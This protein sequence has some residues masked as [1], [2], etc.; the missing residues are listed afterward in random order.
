MKGRLF[1]PAAQRQA[2][3]LAG[4][5]MLGKITK[6]MPLTV[7]PHINQEIVYLN[8]DDDKHSDLVLEGA[9]LIS[10][11]VRAQKW[12]PIFITAG[13][14]AI[15]LANEL[16]II[17]AFQT[18]IIYNKE[19][20]DDMNPEWVEYHASTGNQKQRLSLCKEK[21]KEL[22]GRD[23]I[24]LDSVCTR[25]NTLR[26]THRLLLAAGVDPSRILCAMVL[27]TQGEQL[28]QLQMA[29][30]DKLNLVSF[31]HLDMKD[32]ALTQRDWK[33][34]LQSLYAIEVDAEAE[35]RALSLQLDDE[36]ARA[37]ACL[38]LRVRATD[39]A[40]P[41]DVSKSVISR[42]INNDPDFCAQYL[43]KKL[44]YFTKQ[45]INHLSAWV[46]KT[47]L[48]PIHQSLV[49]FVHNQVIWHNTCIRLFL[50]Q[51]LSAR[52]DFENMLVLKRLVMF[53]RIDGSVRKLQY[54]DLFDILI[55]PLIQAR[56]IQSFKMLF[57]KIEGIHQP[58]AVS[59]FVLVVM[60]RLVVAGRV[61]IIDALLEQK[62]L[63]D[64]QIVEAGSMLAA[65]LRFALFDIKELHEKIS[66]LLPFTAVT[67]RYASFHTQLTDLYN[68]KL[69]TTHNIIAVLIRHGADPDEL[70]IDN[71]NECSLASSSPRAIAAKYFT[72]LPGNLCFTAEQQDKIQALFNLVTSLP[73]HDASSDL[74]DSFLPRP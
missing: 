55:E 34:Q 2:E 30:G 46:D 43:Q 67:E 48:L 13:T 72:N 57:N 35:A 21:A 61:E 5:I 20:P 11:Y 14:N 62:S 1:A 12:K 60:S 18:M 3:N 69:Q 39:R 16:R 24:I 71:Q 50:S 4:S 45:D 27:F 66:W 64:R 40:E 65:L 32:M 51:T 8:L 37:Y 29:N 23:I 68:S 73:S 19:Q 63:I 49:D 10:G 70:K 47:H 44:E 56:A 17:F 54:L 26:A 38:M 9:S 7:L 6:K 36:R 58:R 41:T 33:R 53:T 42:F 74:K 59:G 22:Q 52:N 28:K 31:S 15:T 25:G